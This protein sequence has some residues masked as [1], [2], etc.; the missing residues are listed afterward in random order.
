[1]ARERWATSPKTCLLSLD[2]SWTE[3]IME[4]QSKLKQ[5]Q[6]CDRHTREQDQFLTRKLG[7]IRTNPLYVVF[8]GNTK[9]SVYTE[10]IISCS[11]DESYIID[12][13]QIEEYCSSFG[14]QSLPR[15]KT[16]IDRTASVWVT[17][18]SLKWAAIW[19]QAEPHVENTGHASNF[20]HPTKRSDS[21]RECRTNS[22]DCHGDASCSTGMDRNKNDELASETT[23]TSID[24]PRVCSEYVHTRFARH[25]S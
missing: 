6:L 5:Q 11:R 9:R 16:N 13:K 25:C 20:V 18:P 21:C 4:H 2:D 24:H 3:N 8:G 19:R 23:T 22:T 17:Y 1:M 14:D 12:A 15:E 10:K 7:W